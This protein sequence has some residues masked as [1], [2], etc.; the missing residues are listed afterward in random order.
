LA[1]FF[2]GSSHFYSSVRRKKS[3]MNLFRVVLGLLQD[4]DKNVEEVLVNI[5]K[6]PLFSPMSMCHTNVVG[7]IQNTIK[8]NQ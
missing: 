7:G 4:F 6:I 3:G 5:V 2:Y 8:K 1:T